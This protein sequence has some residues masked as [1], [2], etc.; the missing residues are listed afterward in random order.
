MFLGV[1]YSQCDANGDGDLDVTDIITN[2][3]CILTDCWECDA[4][5]DGNLD[6]T[7]IITNVNCIL[8]DCW[9]DT[10]V[11]PFEMVTVTAGDYTYGQNDNILNIDYD[12]EIMKYEVTNAQY[13]TYLQD[14]LANGEIWIGSCLDTWDW[15]EC[16]NGYYE[17][18]EHVPPGE[19]S[20]YSLD[21]PWDESMN[22]NISFISWNSIGNGR[23][24]LNDSTFLN[25]PVVWVTWYGAN[26]FAEHYGM[27]LPNKYEWEKTARGNT[28]ADY[29]WGE[30]AGDIISD[31][32]NCWDSGDP[33]D[34]GTSPIGYFNGQNGTTD[35]P[36]PYGAYDMVGNVWEWTD[37]W[38]TESDPSRI[39]S[40]GGWN[41][42]CGYF[43][44]S[45]ISL[46]NRPDGSGSNAAFRCVNTHID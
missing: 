10:T 39:I 40:G 7:D 14:A 46:G 18:D 45:W 5:G 43:L 4:N 1:G 33:W 21:D 30:N 3:N 13:L 42:A 36:S 23:F 2:V 24:E 26:A 8:T 41:N 11:T 22:W 28:G 27:R 35:S 38:E 6:I 15:D 31:N 17:G 37:S 44:Q 12:Y 25:H 16:I 20:Y 34:N 9:E 29:P 32:A 19:V